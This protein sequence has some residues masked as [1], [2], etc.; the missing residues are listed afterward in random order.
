M[1]GGGLLASS[2]HRR[3]INVS[4]LVYPIPPLI[5]QKEA[6]SSHTRY[7]PCFSVCYSRMS[8]PVDRCYS[9]HALWV[10][11]RRIY[12]LARDVHSRKPC[13]MSLQYVTVT[14]IRGKGERRRPRLFSGVPSVPPRLLLHLVDLSSSVRHTKLFAG[15]FAAVRHASRSGAFALR[16][17]H[18]A[19]PAARVLRPTPFVR[20]LISEQPQ[21]F[22]Q[23]LRSDV[24]SLQRRSTPRTTRRSCTMTR[25]SSAR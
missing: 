2:L 13:L 1:S 25:P 11:I 15:M 7:S 22:W 24:G 18:R 21:Q 12:V 10:E 9:I 16:A 17:A 23:G 5:L 4:V 20:T 14:T 6:S 3:V 8:A 19:T